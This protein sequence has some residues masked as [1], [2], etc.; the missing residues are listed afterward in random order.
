MR[1]RRKM[2]Q[3]FWVPRPGYV[4]HRRASCCR[5]TI[6]LTVV[7]YAFLVLMKKDGAPL[8]RLRTL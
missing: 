4:I 1:A 5:D 2:M 6:V 7:N 8:F 3:P